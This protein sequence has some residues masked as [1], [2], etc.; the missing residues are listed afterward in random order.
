MTQGVHAAGK[1]GGGAC[2][3]R[4]SNIHQWQKAFS[5]GKI[6]GIHFKAPECG[7]MQTRDGE[8]KA[9]RQQSD[10]KGPIEPLSGGL[11][12]RIDAGREGLNEHG[13]SVP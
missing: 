12:S 4:E 9:R 7:R 8:V 6:S 13:M 2:W 10:K 5:F 1:G 11:V 3:L